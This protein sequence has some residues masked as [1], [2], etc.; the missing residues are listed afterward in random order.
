MKR[1]GC[2][3]WKKVNTFFNFS[4]QR[5][6]GGELIGYDFSL[7]LPEKFGTPGREGDSL[8]LQLSGSF[9]GKH[10]F[11]SPAKLEVSAAEVM[12]GGAFPFKFQGDAVAVIELSCNAAKPVLE[13]GFASCDPC[14]R[15]DSSEAAVDDARAD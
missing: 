7:P 12:E 3:G 8:Q 4:L 13:G 9:Q 14:A 15:H 10:F 6:T 1:R 5:L 2:V 11:C